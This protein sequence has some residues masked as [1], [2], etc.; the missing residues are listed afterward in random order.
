MALQPD[1]QVWS[2]SQGDNF[3]Y[4]QCEKCSRII[5]DEQSAAGPIIRFVND[6]AREFP[7]KTI[8]TLAYQYSRKAPALTKPLDNVQIMLCTIELNR[9]KPI[10]QD[11]TS[12]SFLRDLEDWGKITNHIYLW[13]YTVDFAHSI[14][15][16]P[17]LH[18]LQ[19]NIQL[20]VKNH[21]HEHFQQSNIGVGHEFSELKSFLISKLLWN[22]N[23]NTDSLI[24]QFTNEFYGPA[25]PQIRKYIFRLQDEIVK[26]GEWLDIYGPPTLHQ[27]TFL[28]AENIKAYN[29]YF[30]EA[31]KLVSSEPE[32]LLHVRTARMPL[33]Y[34]MMEIGKNDMFGPRGWYVEA[35]G[36]FIARKEMTQ[37]LENFYR[38]SIACQ[39]TPVNESGL[40][41]KEYYESTLRFIDVQV[42][43]NLA[44][45]KK[46]TALPEPSE[47]YSQGNLDY[48]T[49][50][51]RGAND[52]KVHW[53]G[54]H[55]T[56]FSLTL[57]LEQVSTVNTIEMSTLYD[58]KSWILHPL[59][60]G[61]SVSEN[62]L[63]YQ[64]I[65][66]KTVDDDQRKEPVN[67]LFTFETAGKSFRYIKF[68]V[69]GTLHL[70][71]WHPSA[72][73]ESWVFVDEIVV[74]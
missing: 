6:I 44:F 24:T 1:K 73:G 7:N 63:D 39:S 30:D 13:D 15:P 32:F 38:T 68:D 69:E 34:A 57:D 28:S 72:G 64:F 31:E 52:Y 53:L 9:S 23:V 58:P 47:Q 36:D 56:N 8:S 11:S 10:A 51:V 5:E 22:P 41:P 17:N 21:V 33:Q 27:N 54:W 25:A 65:G 40:S 66:K 19:P 14:S 2:V 62:G 50:G 16:F 12:V 60:V 48:L 45:R 59:S 42:K 74:R 37:T 55:A 18:T 43:G 67:R 70:F 71:P 49:N 3:S 26:S 4:C 46:M 20:F 61:C 35:N 29:Q